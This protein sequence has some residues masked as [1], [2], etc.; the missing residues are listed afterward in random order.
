[1]MRYYPRPKTRDEALGWIEWNRRLYHECGFGLWLISL[2]ET[3]EFVGD[4]GLTLQE[5]N[6]ETEIEVGYHVKRELW[7]SGLATEGARACI[8]YA[9][10]VL[11]LDR[12]V[13]IIDPRN[14]A[15]ARVAEKIGMRREREVVYAS[16]VAQL[17][18]LNRPVRCGAL[19]S[20]D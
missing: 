18:A 12:I 14:A 17:F 20:G 6:G 13:A 11:D 9:T 1:V 2:R 4:C 5:V 15:S 19:P 8:S 16:R 3:G 10:E 7:C